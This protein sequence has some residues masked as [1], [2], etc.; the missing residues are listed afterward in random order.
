VSGYGVPVP[1]VAAVVVVVPARDERE[2]LPGC[3]RTLAAAA[4]ASDL[5]VH[6]V[7]VLDRCTD[8]TETVLVDFPEVAVAVI[9]VEAPGGGGVGRARQLGVRVGL[10]LVPHLE[11]ERVWVCSTDADSQVP[12]N[13]IDHQ[14]ALADAGADLVLG[15]V[16]LDVEHLGWQARY[17]E[18]IGPDGSHTHV[19]GA[20]LGVRASAYHRAGGWPDLRAHEDLHL[21]RA[22]LGAAFARV[23]TTSIN[24]VRTSARLQARAPAGLAGDLRRL[25]S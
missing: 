17:G 16:E 22:I 19:H 10:S 21:T 6:V 1:D 20:N 3:L 9:D 24:P 7:V 11:P 12:P 8:G 2:R 13:W 18:K 4:R 14:V 25:T 23:T 15:T 5:P